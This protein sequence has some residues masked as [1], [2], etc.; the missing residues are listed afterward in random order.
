MEDDLALR[1]MLRYSL[2]QEGLSVAEA[3][4]GR[5]ALEQVAAHQPQL[6]LLDLMMPV[7]D[8]FEFILN[9][10]QNPAWQSIPVVVVTALDLTTDKCLRLNGHIEQ[11]IQKVTLEAGP[12][13]FLHGVGDLAHACIQLI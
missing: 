4:N 5:V 7:V 9:L 13:N 11:V 8:G 2:E 3:G 6:V 10:R 1:E 12:H